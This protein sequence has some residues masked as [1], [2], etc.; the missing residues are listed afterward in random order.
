MAEEQAAKR[1]KTIL[2]SLDKAL[3]EPN[4]DEQLK[5]PATPLAPAAPLEAA[6]TGGPISPFSMT[7][8]GVF[9]GVGGAAGIM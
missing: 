4:A 8:G 9:G 3:D 7:H 6:P 5:P 1:V 2:A